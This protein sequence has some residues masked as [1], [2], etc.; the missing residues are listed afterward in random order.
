MEP[1]IEEPA[2]EITRLEAHLQ[3][4]YHHQ[5]LFAR[6]V[7]RANP[8]AEGLLSRVLLQPPPARPPKVLVT[9][10][11]GVVASQPDLPTAVEASFHRLSPRVQLVAPPLILPGGEMAKEG[12]EQVTVVAEAIRKYHIC[13]HSYV[14][15]IGG[16]AH[17][18]AV[19]FAAA[20]AHRGIRHIRFPTTVLA[21]A[22]SGVGVKNGVNYFGS[23]NF[24]G[25]FAPPFAVVNDLDFLAN[26][27]ARD[28][29]AGF[30]EA[31]KVA[32]I[33]DAA[34]FADL[35]R[36]ADALAT[37]E[38]TAVESLVR[39]C[40][41][42]H[43]RHIATSGD[44]FELGSARPLDFGHW[45]AHKLETLSEHRL[46]H[47]EAVA[48]G[49][50]LDTLYSVRRRAL[51]AADGDR[52]LR[53]LE[54]LGFRCWAPE[55]ALTDAHGQPR[56]LEGLEEFR[57]HLGGELTVT[58][59]DGIGQGVEVHELERAAILESLNALEARCG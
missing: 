51:A 18:D 11:A 23:K 32:L 13:R 19:G 9:I 56:V 50:A 35:E 10:D 37:L 44:P 17:L 31:V 45:S 48:I 34:F 40:A 43:L 42:L 28:K 39:R 14:V 47:G 30:A 4:T 3:L 2:A 25:S 59:L 58:L 33:R 5:V 41:E 52:V 1:Q 55:L 8:G 15:A 54:R 27:P 24:L 16:G 38:A 22:D 36:Q 26:L 57:E 46:R 12:L 6:G 53:L 7:F 29:R 20:T 21:Q 49:V